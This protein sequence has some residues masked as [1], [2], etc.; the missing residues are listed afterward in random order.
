MDSRTYPIQ[1]NFVNKNLTIASDTGHGEAR[2]HVGNKREETR[3]FFNNFSDNNNYYFNLENLKNYLFTVKLEYQY[4]FIK[5]Y[6]NVSLEYWEKKMNEL[7]NLERERI[8]FTLEEATYDGKR[9]Y[10]C[11]EENGQNSV[12]KKYFREIALPLLSE[13]T[14]VKKEKEDTDGY[15]YEFILKLKD[16]LFE[17]K[18]EEGLLNKWN[19]IIYGAPGTGKSHKLKVE[20]EEY[21]DKE[22]IIRITFHSDYSYSEFF[23]SYK[24]IS[25]YKNHADSSTYTRKKINYEGDSLEETE[26]EIKN[27]PNVIYEFNEGPF[28]KLLKK[29]LNNKDSN[30]KD[31]NYLLIIEELNRANTANVFGDIFQLLDRKE[32]VSEYPINISDLLIDSDNETGDILGTQIYLPDNFYI[33]ATM[34]NADQGVYQMDTAFRR[35]W[36]F[37][38]LDINYNS[39]IVDDI[40]INLNGIGEIGWNKFRE[41]INKKLFR[42]FNIREDKLIG[43]FFIDPDTLRK[44]TEKQFHNIFK[45]KI[46]MYICEDILR[47]RNKQLIFKDDSL[48]KIFKRYDEGKES[49]FQKEIKLT[50]IEDE[51]LV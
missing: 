24:P 29:A 12:F 23:G 45:N 38:Y 44:C 26:Y 2:F 19:R 32:G 48:G 33:W 43:P 15:D 21:F 7:E 11:D 35:R 27:D 25:I 1:S 13:L 9:H 16:S 8:Y 50:T 30:K 46:L 37:D 40:T 20:S 18:I 6:K 31:K 42:E 39:Q 5:Q 14:I 51:D 22:N 36:S 41:E 28:L 10:I 3:E 49:I 34:N 4:Q 17:E 47:H